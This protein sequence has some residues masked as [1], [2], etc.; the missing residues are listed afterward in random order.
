[1]AREPARVEAPSVV[2]G[3]TLYDLL[4]QQPTMPTAFAK[5]RAQ[6]NDA[7]GIAFSGDWDGAPSIV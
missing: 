3:L 6:P 5:A 2:T 4:R 7:E 1:M